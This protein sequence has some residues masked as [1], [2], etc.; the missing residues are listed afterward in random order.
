MMG[1]VPLRADPLEDLDLRAA[2]MASA[3]DIPMEPEEVNEGTPC[4]LEERKYD[5]ITS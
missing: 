3:A 1:A 4:S 5:S 2:A